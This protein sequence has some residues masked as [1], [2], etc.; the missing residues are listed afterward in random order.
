VPDCLRTTAP[1]SIPISKPSK[2]QDGKHRLQHDPKETRVP[3]RCYKYLG[4]GARV[5]NRRS[6]G[7]A[8]DWESVGGAG[9]LGRVI[10]GVARA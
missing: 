3:K 10:A 6:A 5:A 1:K 7:A 2:I 9:A 4:G 8:V